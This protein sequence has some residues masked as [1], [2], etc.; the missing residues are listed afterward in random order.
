VKYK[1]IID[2][3]G[4]WQYFQRLLRVL[5]AIA[6]AHDTTIGAVAIRCV[7]D[8][9]A[10]GAA[11]IGAR[12]AEHLPAT[13]AALD[14]SLRISER[15]AVRALISRAEGPHGDVYAL[16]REK[17]GPHASIMRYNLNTA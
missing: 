6:R 10:I 11:I 4:G 14:V 1:L 2:E 9:P 17:S 7:L 3:F 5:H 12:H 16:E 13:L 15:A 8:E